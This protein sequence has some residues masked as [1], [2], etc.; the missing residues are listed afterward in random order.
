MGRVRAC[1]QLAERQGN[2]ET[3][4]AQFAL[5]PCLLLR[6]HTLQLQAVPVHAGGRCHQHATVCG[7][8]AGPFKVTVVLRS[9]NSWVCGWCLA[10]R[11]PGVVRLRD[12]GVMRA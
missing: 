9:E 2:S 4:L 5:L 8:C 7:H 6:P 11:G 10:Q 1:C 3:P 12:D